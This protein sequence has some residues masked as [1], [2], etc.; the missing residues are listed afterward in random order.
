MSKAGT[1]LTKDNKL[2][3]ELKAIYI[4]LKSISEKND[5]SFQN[6][7]ELLNSVREKE[8]ETMIPSCILRTGQVGILQTITKYLKENLNLSFHEIA[9]LLNKDD[10]VV[11]TTYNNAIKKLPFNLKISEPNISLPASVLTDK[12]M[13]PLE[14]IV[15]Y[16]H[17][18]SGLSFNQ[19]A[20]LLNRDNRAIWAVYNK[21]KKGGKK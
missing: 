13:G 8:E 15:C 18:N 21:K 12:S 11:W 16:L 5:I 1:N 6:S 20:K 3:D 4:L 2:N 9:V 10:R 19:I 17:D 14:S 7:L